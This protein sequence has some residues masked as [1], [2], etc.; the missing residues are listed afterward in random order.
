M[1]T[2]ENNKPHIEIY[3][4]FMCPYCHRAK[5]LL[6]SK[7]VEFDNYDVS[8]D[9]ALRSKMTQ[10]ANGRT[11]VPQIFIDDRHIGGSDDLAALDR[12]GKLDTLLGL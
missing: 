3:T 9:S 4:T 6:E 10:R 5:K 7:G 12:D 1:K 11:S 2:M 8:M